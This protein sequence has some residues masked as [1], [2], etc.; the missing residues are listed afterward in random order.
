M[1]KLFQNW[2]LK[3]QYDWVYVKNISDCVIVLKREWIRSDKPWVDLI[4]RA[5]KNW[6]TLQSY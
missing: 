5:R 3:K 6:L 4:T 1:I 2:K